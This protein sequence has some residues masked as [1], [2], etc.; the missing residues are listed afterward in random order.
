MTSLKILL[1]PAL[2]G[3]L[4]GCAQ[5]EEVDTA[6]E[7]EAFLDDEP[8]SDEA[9]KADAVTKSVVV[10]GTIT[11]S[12]AKTG[13]LPAAKYWAWKYKAAANEQIA[14]TLEGPIGSTLAPV[15]MV[16]GPQNGTSWGARKARATGRGGH[17]RLTARLGA[18][19]TYLV[20]LAESKRRPMPFTLRVSLASCT[21]DSTCQAAEV[22][23]DGS[24][25]P[26]GSCSA[27]ADC[28]AGETCIDELCQEDRLC[29]ADTDCPPGLTCASAGCR[30]SSSCR[31]DT[32]CASGQACVGGVCVARQS[33]ACVA[34]GGTCR[35]L[36]PGACGPDARPGDVSTY[37]CGGPVGV[38][39]CVP[40][41]RPFCGAV[42]SRSEGWY[43]GCGGALIGFASCRGQT[44]ECK[45]VGSRSE[46]WYASGTNG[47][48]VRWADCAD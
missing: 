21:S 11:R 39:C 10:K 13:T 4:V 19:G 5:P 32:Q 26:S 22:C 45:A 24:C 18:A 28:V 16:Y 7:E 43:E 27:D 47:A 20:V 2:L 1:L 44:A 12:S 40:L 14:V 25:V 8:L 36:R 9:G 38:M 41:C 23:L 48:L 31:T 34:A 46:G 15:V 29:R 37:S 3:A 33:N 17:L 35:G 6:V 42:G 30:A